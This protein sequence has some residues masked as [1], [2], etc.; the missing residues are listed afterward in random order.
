MPRSH[1]TADQ[2]VENLHRRASEALTVARKR[3]LEIAMRNHP[4]IVEQ[5]YI[6]LQSL[7]MSAE[8]LNKPSAQAKASMS[9]QA[10]AC[11]ERKVNAKREG[12]AKRESVVQHVMEAGSTGL[13]ELVDPIPDKVRSFGGLGVMVLRD[14][15]LPGLSDTVL[16]SPNIRAMK[17][18][19]HTSQ[20]GLL[21]YAE[22]ATGFPLDME[23]Q[24]KLRCMNQLIALGVER[25]MERGNRIAALRLPASWPDDGLYLSHRELHPSVRRFAAEG[26]DQAAVHRAGDDDRDRH[27]R[28]SQGRRPHHPLQLVGDEGSAWHQQDVPE[29]CYLLAALL[30]CPDL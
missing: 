22:F 5:L 13:A 1:L 18:S 25:M 11:A 29:R 6:K 3:Q 24:G 7:G 9:V 27:V 4:F 10:K 2:Q 21:R 19:D 17:S 26:D 12:R 15:F 30:P 23:L 14:K 28:D 8:E 20:A 16:S